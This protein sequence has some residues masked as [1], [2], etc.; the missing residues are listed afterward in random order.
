MRDAGKK[1]DLIV[2]GKITEITAL[3]GNMVSSFSVDRVLKTGFLEL[4]QLYLKGYVDDLTFQV[5]AST[6]PEGQPQR[7][8]LEE[9][10]TGYRVIASEMI[11]EQKPE[12]FDPGI[13][14]LLV[15]IL[16]VA[17]ASRPVHGKN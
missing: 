3:S 2:E 1:A 8:F 4:N 6:I 12:L 7:L 15:L 5:Q 14:G 9:T 13:S 10:E 17:I 11:E 16:I